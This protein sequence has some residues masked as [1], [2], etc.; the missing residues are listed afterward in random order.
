[1]EF[2]YTGEM[3]YLLFYFIMIGN[4]KHWTINLRATNLSFSATQ[5]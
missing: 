5:Y 4:Q 2:G 1:V 3:L